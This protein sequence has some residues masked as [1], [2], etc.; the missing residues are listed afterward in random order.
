MTEDT[1]TLTTRPTEGVCS[2]CSAA[3]HFVE[4]TGYVSSEPGAPNLQFCGGVE[5]EGNRHQVTQD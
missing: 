4:G 5:E 3:V 1:V 2:H